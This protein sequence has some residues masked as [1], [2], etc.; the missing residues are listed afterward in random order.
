MGN[1]QGRP[2]TGR[3]GQH[4]RTRQYPVR[5]INMATC[6]SLASRF[7]ALFR[8]REWGERVDEELDSHIGMETEEN[9]RQGMAP[10]DARAAALR[11]L[12]NKTEVC[13]EVHHMNTILFLD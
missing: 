5:R 9:I 6:R 13:E 7:S 8:Q 10:L 3:L 1:G 11:K 4:P 2:S 12:G